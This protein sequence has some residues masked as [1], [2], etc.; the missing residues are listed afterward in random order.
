MTFGSRYICLFLSFF[1]FCK[2][3]I[4]QN[5][6]DAERYA[7]IP[8][9]THLEAAKGSFTI[10]KNTVIT[11]NSFF[12]NEMKQLRLL[13]DEV[14]YRLPAQIKTSK[15]ERLSSSIKQD[16]TI[17]F[18]R[19]TNIKAPEGYTLSISAKAITISAKEPAGAFR[20][21]ETIRQ[22]IPVTNQSAKKS[23]LNFQIPCVEIEDA[24]LYNWRGMHLD[25]SRH[26]FSIDYLKKFIDV[27]A[28]YKMNKF[29]LHLTDDQG[30]RVE[31][32]KYPKLTEEGAWRTFNNQDSDCIKLSAENPDFAID[33]T[34]IITRNGKKMYGGFYTQQQLKDLV[35]Y[36]SSKHIDIVPEIDMPGHMMAAIH[37]YPFLSC[38]DGSKWGELFSTPVCPCKETTFEFAENVFSEIMDIFPGKYIHLGADEVDRKSWAQSPLC[39]DW[40]QKE[41]L[42][43]V[44]ELQ[45]Y[46]VKRME[47][48]FQ[49]KGRELIGWDEILEGGVSSTAVV[50]YWRSWVPDAPVKA[51]K[52]GNKVIMTPGNPL[53]FDSPPDAHSLDNVYH[54]SV[55]PK[56]LN[57][58]EAKYIQGAQANI[59]TEHIPSENR[60]DYMFM[61]RMTALAE[62]L[63]SGD[64][65][66]DS[67]LQRLEQHY[68]LLDALHVHY[69]LPDLPNLVEENVFTDSAVL[70]VNPP[71]NNMIIHY[72]TD[73]S[74][75]NKTSA[76]LG[77]SLVIKN[78]ITVKLAG[79]TPG[80]ARGDIYTLHYTK[81]T[82]REPVMA[83]NAFPGLQCDY[84]K[85]F[86][87][88]VKAIQDAKPDSTFVI[89]S[90]VVP[91]S[92]TAPS[93]ALQ[94]KGYI[95]VPE[96]GIYSFFLTCDDGGVLNISGKEVVNNDGLHSA[97]EKSGQIALEKGY[98]PFHL[99]FIE[100][101]GGYK[102][103]L[104]YS[105]DNKT[106]QP[107]P[108][109]WL[110]H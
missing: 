29:H 39:K 22:L 99:S 37:S 41:G 73:G 55:V 71:M 23:S 21:V 25:V 80:G 59:W 82:Y 17:S 16:N 62:R 104:L 107:V 14:P 7:L 93:F 74:L 32:K 87:K 12:S 11:G 3:T 40:M 81:E 38:T 79:F 44:D 6:P 15:S 35:T 98:Q 101:G 86:F 90:V 61:P 4:A 103:Q 31:I 67:Y 57:A 78:N 26:F 88:N 9:P 105:K 53:Y 89:D 51:A 33:S 92:V 76:V 65:N 85:A 42:K 34:H 102:L 2:I 54:F 106:H 94:Y 13:I 30:W 43:D 10:T 77:K 100:G 96:T 97:I 8:Y 83:A 72:T 36:A 27:M 48:F 84:Y 66:Y 24:P 19:D 69:R 58:E 75:P 68:A 110:M 108:A 70:A 28:L 56:G 95:N 49:S 50:M 5:I 91:A 20:A 64:N 63:W 45:S 47:K 109:S 46:F 52:H 18:T 1:L 60:A